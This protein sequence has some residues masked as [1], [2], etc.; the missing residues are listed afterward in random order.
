[1]INLLKYDETVATVVCCNIISDNHIK[2]GFGSCCEF[3][4]SLQGI[5]R[6]FLSY[7]VNKLLE[8]PM[9]FFILSFCAL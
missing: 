7:Q 8:K 9:S 1:M 2:Y 6:A 3:G 4:G 5:T